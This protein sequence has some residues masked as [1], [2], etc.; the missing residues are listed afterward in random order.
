MT[1]HYETNAKKYLAPVRAQDGDAPRGFRRPED[2]GTFF[3]A[4]KLFEE[5]GV[6][7]PSNRLDGY[8]GFLG[9]SG[10]AYL[11]S[12]VGLVDRV[13]ITPGKR[14]DLVRDLA[15]PGNA[16][17]SE[18]WSHH[19]SRLENP[20]LFDHAA[21]S[22]ER[23]DIHA[24]QAAGVDVQLLLNRLSYENI[25]RHD[26]KLG[27]VK[28]R[29]SVEHGDEKV[30]IEQEIG[31]DLPSVR[32][33]KEAFRSQM[34]RHVSE[35]FRAFRAAAASFADMVGPPLTG[36]AAGAAL[37]AG[38]IYLPQFVVSENAKAAK[39]DT[40][41]MS[42][43]YDPDT[44]HSDFV[45]STGD[46]VKIM[47]DLNRQE[48]FG[49]MSAPLDGTPAAS[50]AQR[51][52]SSARELTDEHVMRGIEDVYAI[53]ANWN[54]RYGTDIDVEMTMVRGDEAIRVT[55]VD[56]ELDA[57]FVALNTVTTD[58]GGPEYRT[59]QPSETPA[60]DPLDG[61]SAGKR[62]EIWAKLVEGIETPE[63]ELSEVDPPDAP[64]F[65]NM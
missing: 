49:A 59:M 54:E 28:V 7:V 56:Y 3:D 10:E 41:R 47:R 25:C 21:A 22:S 15:E 36:V 27:H 9:A 29:M 18:K 51:A 57:S 20:H 40:E 11:C 60:Y 53:Q 65:G 23:I 32:S 43:L 52:A 34:Q 64:A 19:Q 33:N 13:K 45:V 4:C 38:V 24:I 1:E 62:T 63:I 12:S 6:I 16:A 61:I 39:S 55:S 31:D 37:I 8:R 14:I 26:G 35:S 5:L 17:H 46:A 58:I 48:S 42:V 30:M 50:V 2:D 44:G